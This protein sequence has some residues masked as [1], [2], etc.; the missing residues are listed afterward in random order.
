M[1][2]FKGL[3][4]CGRIKNVQNVVAKLNIVGIQKVIIRAAGKK[5]DMTQDTVALIVVCLISVTPGTTF[6]KEVETN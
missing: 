2:K 3:R 5:I 6:Q 1:K 4:I